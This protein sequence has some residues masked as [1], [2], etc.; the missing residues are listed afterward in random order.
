MVMPKIHMPNS[1]ITTC[2]LL[3][4]LKIQPVTHAVKSKLHNFQP[5]TDPVRVSNNFMTIHTCLF[6]MGRANK[7]AKN[8]S[9]K[10]YS[11]TTNLQMH[12]YDRLMNTNHDKLLRPSIPTLCIPVNNCTSNTFLKAEAKTPSKCRPVP[13]DGN[14][15]TTRFTSPSTTDS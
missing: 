10:D 9:A 14:A 12:Q 3:Q 2:S 4:V 1:H 6:P 8:L 15:K 7:L 5:F 11:A 13:F